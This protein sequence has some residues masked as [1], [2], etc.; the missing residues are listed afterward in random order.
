MTGVSA[1]EV[2]EKDAG[3]RLDRWFK[4]NY[5]GVPFGHLSK[6]LR[7]GQIRLNG[8]RVKGAERLKAGDVIRIPPIKEATRQ[9]TKGPAIS[10]EDA[11]LVKSL[12]LYE[13]DEMIALNKP[14]GL[15]V[16]GGSGTARH[17][18]ALLPALAAETPK[19][20]HRLD[21]DTSGVLV[22]AKSRAAA[23]R[24]ARAFKSRACR[25]VYWALVAGVPKEPEGRIDLPLEKGEAGQREKMLVDEAGKKAVTYYKVL[26]TAGDKAAWVALAPETGRT[27]Q[28]RAH[29]AAIGHAIV[30]DGKYGGKG[31]FLGGLSSKLHL[32]A[33]ALMVPGE[34]A[35]AKTF[36]AP[37]PGHM[38][39]S[40]AVLGFDAATVRD[41]FGGLKP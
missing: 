28:L 19:L 4:A 27:H 2:P 39:E 16:Q 21:K 33:A 34:G 9:T 18:D 41:P 15:A 17:L 37:P 12:I 1:Y 22:V 36:R 7:T 26:D 35:K 32:H 29:M 6:L 5:P 8:K 20:V 25:K 31:A 40:F 14:A 24:L 38:Q 11:E 3:L 10:R 23:N 13:D 30:G